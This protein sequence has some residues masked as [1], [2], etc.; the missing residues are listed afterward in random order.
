MISWFQRR[1]EER[2]SWTGIIDGVAALLF[3]L[4]IQPLSTII[5]WGA[6]IWAVYNFWKA[7]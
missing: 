1:F 3:I 4:V 2:S 5:A 6:L 7:E